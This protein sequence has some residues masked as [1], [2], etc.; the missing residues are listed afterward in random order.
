MR[1]LAAAARRA[2]RGAAGVQSGRRPAVDAG[3]GAGA[4]G[5]ARVRWTR[6]SSATPRRR[7]SR[8]CAGPSPATTAAGT[9]STSTRPTSSS[10]PARPAASCWPSWPRSTSGS[11][12]GLA[13]PGYPAYRNILHALGCEVVD[14]PCGP[15]TRYQPTAAMIDGPRPGRPGRGQP[16]QPDRHHARPGRAGRAGDR[17]A[18]Q[19]GSG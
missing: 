7:A 4:G 14:L 8:R 6:R 11:R 3:P 13:R 16:G 18:R 1:V 10:P 17:I 19:P 5:R 15:E 2:E 12:V 9:A